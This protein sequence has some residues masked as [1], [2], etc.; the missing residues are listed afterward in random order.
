MA[1]S[2]LFVADCSQPS[3]SLPVTIS[4][5][6]GAT[7]G[8]SGVLLH[9]PVTSTARAATAQLVAESGTLQGRRDTALRY[10]HAPSKVDHVCRGI[11]RSDDDH[12]RSQCA[13]DRSG[14]RVGVHH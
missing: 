12:R 11:L 9:A 10:T 3:R 14:A 2:T 5:C 8:E 7:S 6:P 4:T 1:I 13:V